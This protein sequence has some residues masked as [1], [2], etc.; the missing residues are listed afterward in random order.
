[1]YNHTELPTSALQYRMSE[2][3]DVQDIPRGQE[4]L[5]AIGH[6]L[7]CIVFELDQRRKV[8]IFS[9]V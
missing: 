5:E 6:E 4:R 3:L 2:L 7:A 8:E 1:M 9:E